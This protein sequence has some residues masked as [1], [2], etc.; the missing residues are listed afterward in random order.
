MGDAIYALSREDVEKLRNEADFVKSAY[1]KV[2]EQR[3]ELQKQAN[4]PQL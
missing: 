4:I 2:T 3:N 1:E